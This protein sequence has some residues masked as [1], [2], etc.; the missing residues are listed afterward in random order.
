MNSNNGVDMYTSAD[1]VYE[2]YAEIP[3]DER[4]WMRSDWSRMKR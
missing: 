4:S 3:E 2:G 1:E